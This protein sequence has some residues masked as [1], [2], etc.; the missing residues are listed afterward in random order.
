MTTVI[1]D[2][3]LQS[4]QQPSQ[5][6]QVRDR[7][8]AH[9]SANQRQVFRKSI[10]NDLRA[11]LS[12]EQPVG[13]AIIRAHA[14]ADESGRRESVDQPAHVAFGNQQPSGQVVL[15]DAW[16]AVQISQD[17][18]LRQGKCM[19]VEGPFQTADDMV[20]GRRQANPR[21]DGHVAGSSLLV[22]PGGPTIVTGGNVHMVYV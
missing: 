5:L 9:Q 21:R 4:F 18:E 8:A 15:H 12:Q 3:G 16:I 17:F 13:P 20:V 2:R 14:P 10:G 1:C 7:N 22:P 6:A 19:F 11:A